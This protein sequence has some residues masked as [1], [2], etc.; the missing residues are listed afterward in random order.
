MER[1][2]RNLETETCHDKS[3][4]YCK[5]DTH[6]AIESRCDALIVERSGDA[7]DER[8]THQKDGRREDCRKDIFDGCL[9]A[10]VAVLV[11]SDKGAERKRCCLK[12]DDEH[13]EMTA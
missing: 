11:E 2:K 13:Q 12:T 5:H 3:E 10:L 1:N 9:M 7:V 8:Q 4:G 6:I